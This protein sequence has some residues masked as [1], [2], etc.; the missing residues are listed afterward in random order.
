MKFHHTGHR[1]TIEMASQEAAAAGD[2]AA[3]MVEQLV[4]ALT[5]LAALRTGQLPEPA[6]TRP[7]THRR[8]SDRPGATMCGLLIEWPG[9]RQAID[10]TAPSCKFCAAPQFWAGVISDVETQLLPKL[11]GIR[12]AS[13]RTWMHQ[14]GGSHGQYATALGIPRSTA[15]S[16]REALFN[17][18]LG[19]WE[20]WAA[21]N[22]ALTAPLRDGG[23]T[24]CAVHSARPQAGSAEPAATQPATGRGE[25]PSR[26]ATSP[27]T[28]PVPVPGWRHPHLTSV[29]LRTGLDGSAI[30]GTYEYTVKPFTG[31]EPEP[32]IPQEW[33]TKAAGE[34]DWHLHSWRR[35][36]ILPVRE[37]WVRARYLRLVKALY[38]PGSPDDRLLARTFEEFQPEYYRRHGFDH[39]GTRAG[40]AWMT[41][42]AAR[43]ELREAY[44]AMKTQSDDYW[45]A[46][47]GRI[48]DATQDAENAAGEFDN[49]AHL[50]VDITVWYE[51]TWNDPHKWSGIPTAI[52]SAADELGLDVE[53]WIIPDDPQEYD[54][55]GDF[56]AFGNT[57]RNEIKSI[58]NDGERWLKGVDRRRSG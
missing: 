57:A 46:G 13:T 33:D 42:A 53:G 49:I 26:S 15:Q 7:T 16:R 25:P 39:P 38:Q 19:E 9:G 36:E 11:E 55:D 30:P 35:Q 32:V 2:D 6:A 29:T 24:C 12:D 51:Q 34:S 18:E 40:D 48:V 27:A 56:F 20:R 3:A 43:D 21:P 52:T 58:I 8:R 10:E 4:T 14:F 1:L 41:Y 17:R 23:P 5:A 54:D 47:L 45:S 31:D 22:P 28:V 37:K 50:F 44:Q